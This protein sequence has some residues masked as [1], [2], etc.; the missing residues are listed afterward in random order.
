MKEESSYTQHLNAY[1]WESIY[2][3]NESQSSLCWSHFLDSSKWRSVAFFAQS[4]WS[5]EFGLQAKAHKRFADWADKGIGYK[6]LDHFANNPVGSC[7]ASVKKQTITRGFRQKLQRLFNKSSWRLWCTGKSYW[8]YLNGWTNF[9]SQPRKSSYSR[10]WIWIITC[11]QGIWFSIGICNCQ[12]GFI[13]S[14]TK[15]NPN[16]P[17]GIYSCTR[18]GTRLNVFLVFLNI[19]GEYSQDSETPKREKTKCKNPG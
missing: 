16:D 13:R 15:I 1:Q 8:F 3:L 11:G 5:L 2:V 18:Q 6:M 12:R 17:T 4:V 9:R 14:S 10:L 19:T 7:C